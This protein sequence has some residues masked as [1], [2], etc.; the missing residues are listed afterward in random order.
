[1]R[2]IRIHLFK[3]GK[4]YYLRWRQA[5]KS[6]MRSVGHC[7]RPWADKKR[8]ELEDQINNPQSVS[9]VVDREWGQAVQDYV[10]YL[11]Q[12]MRRE[13]TVVSYERSLAKLKDTVPRA[14]VVGDIKQRH[15]LAVMD[16]ARQEF[17]TDSA[18]HH[19]KNLRAFFNWAVEQRVIT[20]SPC[21]G[22]KELPSNTQ[23]GT[24]RPK[25]IP[26][27]D[28]RKVITTARSL[29]EADLTYRNHRNYLFLEL[30]RYAG[31]RLMEAAYLDWQN[32]KLDDELLEIRPKAGWRIKTDQER[33]IA[34]HPELVKVLRE[35]RA[36]W[37]K[38]LLYVFHSTGV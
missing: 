28:I 18:N 11:R 7:P 36:K 4:S 25:L 31:M 3:R 29:Y 22:I 38:S 8:Q 10:G 32:V 34:I 26:P 27:R 12:L 1:M 20:E 6:W 19:F 15:I 35:Y 9:E 17:S 21:R 23:L 16:Q 37:P 5:G 33:T 13:S 24:A 30:L 14:R 2:Y